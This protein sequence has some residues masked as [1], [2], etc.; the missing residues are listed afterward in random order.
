MRHFIYYSVV[1]L[2]GFSLTSYGQ[3]QFSKSKNINSLQLLKES[4]DYLGGSMTKIVSLQISTKNTEKFKSQNQFDLLQIDDLT[5]IG[6]VGEPTTYVKSLK[7]V[8]KK[9]ARIT[10]IRLIEGDYVDVIGK[11]NLA[12]RGKPVI[13]RQGARNDFE[14]KRNMEIYG[15]DEY[16]PGK[17][18]NYIAGKGKDNTVVYIQLFPVQYNP[19][20]MEAVLIT[21]AKIEI[22][23]VIETEPKYGY[24]GSNLSTNAENII[25]TTQ[26][27]K[28]YADTLKELHETLENVTT[29]V[30]TIDSIIANYTAAPDPTITGWP[31][32]SASSLFIRYHYETAMKIVSYLR[33]DDAHPNLESITILGDAEDIPPSY[34]FFVHHTTGG[35]TYDDFENMVPS[36][37]FYA[38]PDYDMV[39]NYEIGRLPADTPAEAQLIVQKIKNWKTNLNSSWFNNTQLVGGQPFGTNVFYGELITADAINKGYLN[40]TNINKNFNTRQTESEIDVM[41]YFSDENTGMIYHVGHGSGNAMGVASGL[42][43]VEDWITYSE[44]LNL[45]DKQKYPVV[46]SIACLNGAYDHDLC[47]DQGGV[48]FSFNT[49]SF[50]E[51]VLGSPAGGIAYI[52][53]TRSNYGNPQVAFDLNGQ[54]HVGDENY[55]AK[56]LTNVFKAWSED[57]LTL[58]AITNQAYAYYLQN[59]GLADVLDSLTYFEFAFFGDPVLTILPQGSNQYNNVTFNNLSPDPHTSGSQ[60]FGPIYLKT[61]NTSI[62][63]LISG[64]TNSPTVKVNSFILHDWM[65]D[66][67]IISPFLSPIPIAQNLSISQ[68]F[69]YT[70]TPD[71]NFFKIGYGTSFETVD[72]KETRIYFWN[73][74]NC[75]NLCENLPP[76][77]SYLFDAQN[78]NGSDY[79]LSW[80]EAKDYDGQ[81]SSYTIFEGKNP[82]NSVDSCNSIDNWDTDD[83]VVSPGGYNS[84]SCLYSD[85]LNTIGELEVIT[86]SSP[87]LV[88]QGD[89][90]SFWRKYNVGGGSTGGCGVSI[91][92]LGQDTLFMKIREWTIGQS[93]WTQCTIDLSFYVGKLILIRFDCFIT[94]GNNLGLW[95]D[96]IYPVCQFEETKLI[97][98]IT[99]TTY[100]IADK[101]KGEYY[102]KVRAFD[103]INQSSNWSNTKIVEVLVGIDEQDAIVEDLSLL[104][105]YPNPFSLST[106]ISYQ[107]QQTANVDLEIYNIHGQIV[108][109][110]IN[111][112]KESGEHK[113]LW[114]GK[115]DNRQ[116]V[117]NGIYFYKIT[118]IPQGSERGYS[119]MKKM[120][121]IR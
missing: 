103:N 70:F 48:P 108:R 79:D 18:V 96:D 10:G 43:S 85:G 62:P 16:F 95:I 73:N 42:E 80:T 102:Y 11:I 91:A 38:S 64:E 40:G 13:W 53:G 74:D 5:T 67:L 63:V 9:N 83:F 112:K 65:E 56:M 17:T 99:D 6:K 87:Y 46:V 51:G 81:I 24:N 52:G 41:P 49:R 31:H 8:L 119:V 34:Y 4:K 30:I 57:N 25:L 109:N 69:E 60:S 100:H 94:A 23:Y 47:D 101:P 72:F 115:S 2:F 35:S 7:V 107:L 121:M 28:L 54:M 36:D 86:S 93:D 22:S 110:L 19:V 45:P 27:F 15:R 113:E 88:K 84:D 3:I 117:G 33:D 89:Q 14:L 106:T 29:E 1:F 39:L 116:N 32:V 37:L 26:E 92:Q 68:P 76:I 111:A 98:N 20:T 77:S 50:A 66:T 82:G 97:E 59:T 90:L 78:Q 44:L 120:V 58:G 114:D 75:L 61:P 12:P 55:M 71:L 118:V 21:N 104:K 105:N